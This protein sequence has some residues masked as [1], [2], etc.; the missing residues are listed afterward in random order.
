M[1]RRTIVSEL[2]EMQIG[3]SKEFPA[4][5]CTTIQSSASVYG[6]KWDRKY[7]TCNDRERR[8]ITVTRRK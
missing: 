4:E 1:A 6:F 5:I 3:E 8:V 2:W 7:S